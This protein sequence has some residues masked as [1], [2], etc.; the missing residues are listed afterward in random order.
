MHGRD[1]RSQHDPEAPPPLLLLALAFFVLVAGAGAPPLVLPRG[2]AEEVDRAAEGRVEEL[3]L[4]VRRRE[5]EGRAGFLFVAGKRRRQFPLSSF[6]LTL[7]NLDPPP[8][9]PTLS[10]PPLPSPPLSLRPSPEYSRHVEDEVASFGSLVERALLEQVC[11]LQL[12]GPGEHRSQSDE[13]GAAAPGGAVAVDA[14]GRRDD[15]V[16]L[17]EQLVDDLGSHEA[18]CSGDEGAHRCVELWGG[19]RKGEKMKANGLERSIV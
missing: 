18:R 6:S 1:R 5:D 15:V 19:T 14:A 11:G 2:R 12:E 9:L 16:A 17:G 13:V 4:R 3:S 8:T 10:L 7:R